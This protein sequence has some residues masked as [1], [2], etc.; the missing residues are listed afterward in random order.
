[1]EHSRRC[2]TGPLRSFVRFTGLSVDDLLAILR[3]VHA[4]LEPHLDDEPDVDP[5]VVPCVQLSLQTSLHAVHPVPQ[6]APLAVRGFGM[7]LHA[8]SVVDG[9]DRRR[10]ERVC[11]YLLRP[12][13]SLQAV[14]SLEDGRVRLHMP[15]R[16]S[17]VDMTPEQ[18]IGK[19]AAL[20]P[21]PR[22][23]MVRYGGVFSNAHH[24][25]PRIVPKLARPD[26]APPVQLHLFADEIATL[27]HG[28][29]AP[30]QP[31]VPGQLQLLA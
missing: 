29:R 12:A 30:P 25:R 21:P 18:F 9:R 8:E 20:V 7:N 27:L 17:W 14:Q 24:L 5:G 23:H 6:P 26:D 19:L 11:R 16:G 1:M 3:R 15:R 31:P 28:A 2:P 4:Q 10:L 13:F 22:F